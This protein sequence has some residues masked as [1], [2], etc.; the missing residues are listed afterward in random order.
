M[1][2]RRF[3]FTAAQDGNGAGEQ[4]GAS[5]PSRGGLVTYSIATDRKDS[6]AGRVSASDL[7]GRVVEF[8]SGM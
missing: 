1:R 7:A 8:F 2:M 5:V 4:N 3:V 6:L